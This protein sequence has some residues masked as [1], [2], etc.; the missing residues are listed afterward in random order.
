[1]ALNLYQIKEMALKSRRAVYSVQQLANLI[2]KPKSIAK[3]YLSRLVKKGLAKRLLRG[4]ITF[5]DDDYII[6]TQLLE[7]SYIS[8]HSALLFH[9]LIQQVPKNTDCVTPKNSRNYRAHGINYHKI[10]SSFFYG[11]EKYQ[12][13]GSYIFVADPEKAIIDGI[14]LHL[15][16]I[17][18]I[19]D[20]LNKLNRDKLNK[21][22]LRFKGK[23]QKRLKAI[24]YD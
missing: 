1:M 8:L 13:A 2:G 10:P 16:P 18:M 19:R 5:V 14:Y 6:A 20:I 12:K 4:R 7:P 9:G 17:N 24:C 3:V 15:I 22:I 21:Y 23:G 11:Y